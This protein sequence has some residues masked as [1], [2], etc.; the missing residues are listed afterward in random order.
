MIFVT[1]GS[2]FPFDRLVAAMDNW[3]EAGH[4]EEM[5]AQIGAGD[6]RPVRM[7]WTRMM[8]RPDFVSMARKASVI[9]AHA[10]IGSILTATEIG[11][12]IVLLPRHAATR[13]H[14]SDHQLHTANW[15]RDRPGIFVAMAAGELGPAIAAA[16][17]WSGPRPRISATAPEPFLERLRQFLDAEGARDQFANRF[18]L[19]T[20]KTTNTGIGR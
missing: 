12:P 9:V 15:V 1:V 6:Y 17:A 7:R 3:A 19:G 20:A 5:F 16:K 4:S 11:K 18:I 8:S 10:G 2:M 14:T 13:E